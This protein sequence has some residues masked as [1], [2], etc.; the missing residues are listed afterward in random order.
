ME[1]RGNVL[2]L[3]INNLNSTINSS[4]KYLGMPPFKLLFHSFIKNTMIFIP[5]TRNSRNLFRFQF[6]F[7]FQLLLRLRYKR[8]KKANVGRGR[9]INLFK[10]HISRIYGQM[11]EF[12]RRNKQKYQVSS[13]ISTNALSNSNCSSSQPASVS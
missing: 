7:C 3:L 12:K 1:F 10:S 13:N 9:D 5:Y 2:V 11:A 8:N 4:Q 6:N